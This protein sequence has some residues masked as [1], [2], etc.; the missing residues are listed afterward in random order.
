MMGKDM[1]VLKL[2]GQAVVY[3]VFAIVVGYLATRPS[4]TYSD[5]SK[6]RLL[7]S[8]TH[9]GKAA[10]GCRKRSSKELAKLA[11]NMRKATICSRER[12]SLLFEMSIDG[13][14]VHRETLVPTGMRSDGPSR[15]YQKFAI[16]A[17]RHDLEFKLRDTDR[18]EGFD[19]VRKETVEMK[20]GQNLAVDFKASQGGFKF[21]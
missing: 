20:P 13:E 6:A 14:M 17:G 19:Y 15:T 1:N 4:W 11:P 5:G 12:V 18:T 2:L 3:G 21:E 8:F 9:G 7:V 10:G 16:S